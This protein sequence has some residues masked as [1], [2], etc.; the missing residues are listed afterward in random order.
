MSAEQR[1]QLVIGSLHFQIA[2]LQAE[3][4]DLKKKLA[5]QAK[6]EPEK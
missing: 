1:I 3:N 5:E 2:V 6:Q 4:D